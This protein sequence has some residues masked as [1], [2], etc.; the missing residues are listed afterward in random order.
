MPDNFDL[1]TTLFGPHISTYAPVVTAALARAGPFE[2]KFL[3]DELWREQL[4]TGAITL[5]IQN[6]TVAVELLITA[7]LHALTSLARS[8]RW[9]EAAWRE[10]RAMSLLGFAA[11]CRC[12]IE[13]IGDTVY[14]LTRIPGTIVDNRVA[15][16]HAVTGIMGQSIFCSAEIEAEFIHFEHGRKL[17]KAEKKLLAPAHE[18]KLAFE[19]VDRLVEVGLYGAK[20]LYDELCQLSHPS[21]N[22]ITLFYAPSDDGGL[23]ANG[24]REASALSDLIRAHR[25]TL[26]KLPPAAFNSGLQILS[27]LV[28]FNIFP[29]IPELRQFPY[30][31]APQWPELER[32]L[33]D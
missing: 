8:M 1:S 22:S 13:A 18:G 32:K 25:D 19:Y 20:V 28:K 10:R 11:T 14:S 27:V 31:G 26:W 12:L 16:K 15:L 23:T 17:K 24:D 30:I 7:H 29:R 5:E 3:D 4:E 21:K 2:H 6:R 9:F 33:Q